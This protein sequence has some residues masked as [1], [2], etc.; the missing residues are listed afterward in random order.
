MTSP[1]NSAVPIS[2]GNAEPRL[3]IMTQAEPMLEAPGAAWT[4]AAPHREQRQKAMTGFGRMS[5][6]FFLFFPAV[7]FGS[8]PVELPPEFDG[9][10]WPTPPAITSEVTV[11]NATQL[12]AALGT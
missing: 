7:F 6:L 10:R 12:T 9:L 2:S 8:E 4:R 11:S 5:L 3:G 1:Q